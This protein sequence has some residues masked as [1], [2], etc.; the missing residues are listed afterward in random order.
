MVDD[1]FFQEW[2]IPGQQGVFA[3][4]LSCLPHDQPHKSQRDTE[5]EQIH[6]DLFRECTRKNHLIKVQPVPEDDQ[7]GHESHRCIITFGAPLHK[8][9]QRA[10]EV[11]DQVQVENALVG[12]FEPVL[13]IDGFLGNVGIPDQHKLGKPQVSPENGEGE[14]ELAEVM[15]VLLVHILQVSPVLEIDDE[16]CH[17]RYARYEGA[18]E[19]IPAVHGRE[20][21]RIDAHQPQPGRY[22]RHRQSE[23]NDKNGR[24]YRIRKD[25]FPAFC[26]AKGLIVDAA[27][28]LTHLP[29]K[30]HPQPDGQNRINSKERRAQKTFLAIQYLVMRYIVLV[31]PFINGILSAKDNAHQDNKSYSADGDH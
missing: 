11:D 23:P 24:P 12:T 13:E 3:Q 14:L 19:C 30:H 16:Q 7:Y 10:K 2:V 26:N 5:I 17:Q 29:A 18:G 6:M 25:I 20:P 31:Q 15:Q 22:G 8:D 27:G 4:H 21:M 9:Q 1:T 28:Q